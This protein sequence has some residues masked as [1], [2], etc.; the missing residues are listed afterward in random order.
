MHLSRYSQ[1]LL[2]NRENGKETNIVCSGADVHK[3]INEHTVDIASIHTYEIY[4]RNPETGE[5]GWQI[6]HV[7]S[8]DYLIRQFPLFDCIITKNDV[9]VSECTDFLDFWVE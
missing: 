8:T 5:G 1:F 6:E 4:T 3:L 9:H 2:A 7:R